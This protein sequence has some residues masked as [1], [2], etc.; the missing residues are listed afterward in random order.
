MRL[1]AERKQTILRSIESQG[2][3]TEALAAQIHGAGTAKRLEDL[4]LPFKPKKQ[5]LATLARSRG[6]EPLAREILDAVVGGPEFD[7]R[8]ADFVS[9]D[10]KVPT[11]ADAL[12]GAGHIL[13]EQFSEHA[14]LRQRLRDVIQRTGRLVCSQ[15]GPE[16]GETGE[17]AEKGARSGKAEKIEVAVKP[18]A[19]AVSNQPPPVVAEDGA[20]AEPALQVLQTPDAPVP[21]DEN[22][23]A[24]PPVTQGDCP[25]DPPGDP[26]SDKTADRPIESPANPPGDPPADPPGD[27]SADCPGDPPSEEPGAAEGEAQPDARVTWDGTAANPSVYS[28]DTLQALPASLPASEAAT[29]Q[30][31]AADSAPPSP[32][33]EQRTAAAPRGRRETAAIGE[34]AGRP[35]EA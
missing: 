28:F 16:P 8:A 20:V 17:K 33:T 15:I 22:A 11:A 35:A 32:P 34:A 12:L 30:P 31:L 7:A 10:R 23:T 4:Y 26:P 27:P 21:N 14:E 6:L 9:T 29:A 25:D 18:T 1:L 2:K 24:D 19:E 5:T 3:L 13:A